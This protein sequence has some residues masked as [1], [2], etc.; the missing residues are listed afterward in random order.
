MDKVNTTLDIT[1]KDGRTLRLVISN[2]TQSEY[3]VF[4]TLYSGAFPQN[5]INRFAFSH[6]FTGQV[7]GWKL[8]NPNN[9]YARLGVNPNKPDCK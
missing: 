4:P 9:D 5:P 3:N 7:D 8:Y 1:T 2:A 6:L